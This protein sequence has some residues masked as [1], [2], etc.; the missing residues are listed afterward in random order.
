LKN[1]EFR[2]AAE[3]GV[4][5]EVK[6]IK[7]AFTIKNEKVNKELV[8]AVT[9]NRTTF[10]LFLYIG[11]DFGAIADAFTCPFLPCHLGKIDR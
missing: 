3:K 4:I 9:I 8:G 5:H 1:I 11:K 6:N 2:K 7:R 10:Y